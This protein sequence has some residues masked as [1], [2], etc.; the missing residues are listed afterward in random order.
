MSIPDD[1]F[2]RVERE[3]RRIGCTRSQLYA[4]ALAEYLGAAEDPEQD[5]VTARLNEIAAEHHVDGALS[6]EGGRRLVESGAWEW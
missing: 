2:D 4:R 5:P 1:L 3:A 6:D